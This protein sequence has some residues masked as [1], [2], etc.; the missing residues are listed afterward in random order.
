MARTIIVKL[1]GGRVGFNALQ[2]KLYVIWN[3][4]GAFQLM[5]LQNDFYLI[6]FQDD[7]DYSKVLTDG[8]WIIF[9][10][11]LSV[12]PW[13]SRFSTSQDSIE[14][15]VVRIR[16]PGLPEGYYLNCLLRVIGQAVGSVIKLDAHTDGSR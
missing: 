1:L 3:P 14:S 8:P 16:L 9:G 13:T 2:N 15:Q 7:D 5:D 10:K 12:R 4:N 6:R 11:Y